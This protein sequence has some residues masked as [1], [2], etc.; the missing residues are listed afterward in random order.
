MRECQGVLISSPIPD[1]FDSLLL[2]EY[3]MLAALVKAMVWRVLDFKP[4]TYGYY[5]FRFTLR[6][7]I[8]PSMMT[9][10]CPRPHAR[11]QDQPHSR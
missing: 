9:G 8:L 10:P 6:L 2:D 1:I 5:F 4:R 11:G 3:E 7:A